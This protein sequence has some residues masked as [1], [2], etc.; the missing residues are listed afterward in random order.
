MSNRGG[1]AVVQETYVLTGVEPRPALADNDVPRDDILVWTTSKN[2][3]K[4]LDVDIA[5]PRTS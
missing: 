5:H 4:H 2:K 1:Y 3:S